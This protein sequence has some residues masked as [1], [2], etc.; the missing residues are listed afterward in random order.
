MLWAGV[1][2]GVVVT[3]F[4]IVRALKDA[5]EARQ[6]KAEFDKTQLAKEMRE[7]RR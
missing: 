2:L 5:R 4:S 1:A 7:R 6:A 3:I